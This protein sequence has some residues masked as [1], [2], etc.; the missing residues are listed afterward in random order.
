MRQQLS[1]SVFSTSPKWILGTL[2]E[3]SSCKWNVMKYWISVLV[4]GNVY[5][6]GE[7]FFLLAR[8]VWKLKWQKSVWNQHLTLFFFFTTSPKIVLLI[9][10]SIYSKAIYHI[11]YERAQKYFPEKIG[12]LSQKS[13]S[14][15]LSKNIHVGTCTQKMQELLFVNLK[16]LIMRE[17]AFRQT[18][19]ITCR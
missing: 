4:F 12:W 10:P 2:H 1:M 19:M 5:K 9:S 16:P 7:V 6:F 3:N 18:E 13:Q 11:S 15:E 14:V 8:I 17:G